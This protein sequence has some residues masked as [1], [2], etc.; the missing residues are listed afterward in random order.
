MTENNLILMETI[1]SN[2]GIEQ[3]ENRISGDE[4]TY[5]VMVSNH[6]VALNANRIVNDDLSE[7]TDDESDG[8]EENNIFEPFLI[9]L[10]N[11]YLEHQQ[12]YINKIF[13]TLNQ[14]FSQKKG[15]PATE[16][17]NNNYIFD[18]SDIK[19]LGNQIT[20]GINYIEYFYNVKNLNLDI[21]KNIVLGT[22]FTPNENDKNLYE[23]S[24]YYIIKD[25]KNII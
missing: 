9:K 23:W 3:G 8:E 14:K 18:N 1:S 4:N 6:Q 25:K 7:S 11:K 5:S 2:L 15:N 20:K 12:N 10:C 16:R 22:Y 17:Y 19:I 13:N 24:I 21:D